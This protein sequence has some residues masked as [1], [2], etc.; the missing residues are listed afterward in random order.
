MSGGRIEGNW[1]GG[2][3]EVRRSRVFRN[4]KPV[5]DTFPLGGWLKNQGNSAKKVSSF[6]FSE[7]PVQTKAKEFFELFGCIGR[8]VEVSISPRR[9]KLGKCFGFARFIEVEDERMLGVRLDN[10]QILGKKIH[11]N[12]PRFQRGSKREGEAEVRNKSNGRVFAKHQSVSQLIGVS[13]KERDDR[14]YVEVVAKR[15]RMGET[16]KE[17]IEKWGFKVDE[18]RRTRLSKAFVGRVK[19]PG[20]AYNIQTQFEME[21]FFTIKATPMGGSLVL[22]EETEGGV[23]A[24]LIGDGDKWWK[25]WFKDISIWKEDMVDTS[26]VVWISIFGVP[27]VAWSVDFFK[28]LAE[29]FGSFICLDAQTENEDSYDIARI[30]ISVEREVSIPERVVVN[31]DG[32]DFT[33]MIREDKL[34][35]MRTNPGNRQTQNPSGESLDSDGFSVN[36]MQVDNEKSVGG[37]SIEYFENVSVNLEGVVSKDSIVEFSEEISAVK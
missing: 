32:N 6:Y 29:R 8:V 19:V 26:K 7:F 4:L 22:L 21:G 28:Q 14:S 15:H 5:W 27:V 37:D 35:A 23:I 24:D 16:S 11:A 12:I 3:Q 9:N 18:H 13:A 1:G 36:D 17:D 2:W 30:M 20:S 33:L 34:D 10:V 31:I 25:C